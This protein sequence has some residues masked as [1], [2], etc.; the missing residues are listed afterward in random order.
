LLAACL[1]VQ[2]CCSIVG[3]H[4][5][6]RVPR[7]CSWWWPCF[8]WWGARQQ[9]DRAG[10]AIGQ[11][12]HP[13]TGHG[14]HTRVTTGSAQGV[15]HRRASGDLVGAGSDDGL[16]EVPHE[17]GSV[18]VGEGSEQDVGTDPSG[19]A[20]GH[21]ASRLCE[22]GSSREGHY[23][24]V[25]P[26]DLRRYT[27]RRAVRHTIAFQATGFEAGPVDVQID[28]PEG[29]EGPEPEQIPSAII[30][31]L[32]GPS[33]QAT[34][35]ISRQ[36]AENV[37]G[38][39][40]QAESMRGQMPPEAASWEPEPTV[41]PASMLFGVNIES[42][43]GA[44]VTPPHVQDD[45]QVVPHWTVGLQDADGSSI[46]VAVSDALSVTVIR[47]LAD[48]TNGTLAPSD[49]LDA[50]APADGDADVEEDTEV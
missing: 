45:G 7:D 34:A 36:D 30:A 24:A 19:H 43:V 47:A 48:I 12:T 49:E 13:T 42:L 5:Y 20:E 44:A 41:M 6:R 2:G 25:L 50:G 15:P 38:A 22:N 32:G 26:H 40:T 3:N 18:E 17:H 10:Q 27:T 9:F 1:G 4:E 35:F 21:R 37:M 14:V 28:V 23:G 29:E 16:A 8:I 11:Q 39:F 33:V 46:Q 31:F